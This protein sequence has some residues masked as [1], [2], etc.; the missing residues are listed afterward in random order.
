MILFTLC[1]TGFA[2]KNETDT[3]SNP[4]IRCGTGKGQHKS[5]NH[6]P[7]GKLK[8]NDVYRSTK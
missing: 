7:A 4:S 1:S 3:S 6:R 5:K 8:V 2:I